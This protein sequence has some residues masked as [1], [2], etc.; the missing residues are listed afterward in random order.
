MQAFA[1]M[2][3]FFIGYWILNR[4]W[5]SILVPFLFYTPTQIPFYMQY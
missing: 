5:I 1:F 2:I 4:G 3:R